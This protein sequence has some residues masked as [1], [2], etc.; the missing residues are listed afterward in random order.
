MEIFVRKSGAAQCLYG[1]EIDLGRLGTL[2]IKR[3]SHVEPAKDNTWTVDLTPVGG[4]VF[5]G[6]A[7]RGTALAAEAEWLN[8]TMAH[9]HVVAS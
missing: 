4:P 5:T 1:E 6:F 9:T 2:D 3:A 8:N 7:N